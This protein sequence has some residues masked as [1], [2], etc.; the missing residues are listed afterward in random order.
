MARPVVFAADLW[1]RGQEIKK[2]LERRRASRRW[3]RQRHTRYRKPRFDNRR[4]TADGWIAPSLESRV[5]NVITWVKR[6]MRVCPLV[7]VSQELVRFDM[8][9]MENPEISGVQYQQGALAGYEV[10]EYLLEKW[11]RQCVYCGAKDVPLEVE[12]ICPR[13]KNGSNRLGNVTGACEPC[14][15]KKGTQDI[16]VLL[17]S[18]GRAGEPSTTAQAG[19]ERKHTGLMRPV[20]VLAPLM[21]CMWLAWFH[22]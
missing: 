13:A 18:V 4:N 5:C 10:R 15:Q 7:A 3:R 9:F 12:H 19:D 17:L 20:S 21:C 16:R 8:Q 14:N 11:G 22:S 6:L 2:S 1:H